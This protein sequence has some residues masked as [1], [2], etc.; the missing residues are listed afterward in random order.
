MREVGL[1]DLAAGLGYS[2]A[3]SLRRATRRWFGAP[4]SALRRPSESGK[5]DL[6]PKEQEPVAS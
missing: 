5:A 3:R 6:S 4:P 2:E 1:E